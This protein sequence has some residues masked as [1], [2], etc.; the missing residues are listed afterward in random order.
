MAA[1]KRV[2]QFYRD[3][4]GIA[5]MLPKLDQLA[6]PGVRGGGMEDWGDDLVRR[7]GTALRPGAELDRDEAADLLHR[8]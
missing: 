5:Y 8:R 7:I 6:I 2:L 3:Y 4:F 1:T